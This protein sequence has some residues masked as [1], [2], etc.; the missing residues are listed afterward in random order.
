MILDYID[1]TSVQAN[2]YAVQR[3]RE[4]AEE[5]GLHGTENSH[6]L[7]QKGMTAPERQEYIQLR[8]R[9]EKD[10]LPVADID[11]FS[12][13]AMNRPDGNPRW[14]MVNPMH[15][16]ANLNG[17]VWSIKLGGWRKSVVTRQYAVLANESFRYHPLLI[18]VTQKLLTSR[19]H[20][21]FGGCQY[22]EAA[23][24][25]P[26][27]PKRIRELVQSK[28]VREC[29]A[30]AILYQP[31]GWSEP[32]FQVPDPDPALLVRKTQKDQWQCA[33]VWGHDGPNIMEFTH[34]GI[35]RETSES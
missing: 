16:T 33:A 8:E 30:C 31:T 15:A 21:Q 17:G 32:K 3:T 14:A 7:E 29:F 19:S 26:L 2:R 9:M 6:I 28:A 20:Q 10:A 35:T 1:T 22:I 27:L 4:F 34:E 13:L 25:F 12:L 5:F 11:L 24:G 23:S 18:D